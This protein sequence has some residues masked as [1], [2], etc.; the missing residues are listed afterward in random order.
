M[1]K[2]TAGTN[3]TKQMFRVEHFHPDSRR[4]RYTAPVEPS[5]DTGI[6]ARFDETIP[7]VND[8]DVDDDYRVWKTT[9]CYVANGYS[10]PLLKD[11][12]VAN[13]DGQPNYFAFGFDIHV[14]NT[15]VPIWGHDGRIIDITG[16]DWD[17]KT[18]LIAED[19]EQLSVGVTINKWIE[20]DIYAYTGVGT[21]SIL[22]RAAIAHTGWMKVRKVLRARGIV[23]FWNDLTVHLMHVGGT[24]YLRDHESFA[25]DFA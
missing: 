25:R 10:F 2:D 11:E 5:Y 21:M 15:G 20:D 7:W 18:F 3:C 14:L 4:V 9:L 23:L 22:R 8:G 17:V 19:N 13:V 1:D 24:A 12:V 6:V 16:K